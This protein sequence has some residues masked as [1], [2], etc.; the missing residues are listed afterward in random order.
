MLCVETI[1]K[2]RRYRLVEGKSIKAISREL[3]L[4]RNTVR[5]VLRERRL[6]SLFGN[7][8]DAW[9]DEKV[10]LFVDE[11]VTYG[12]EQVGGLRVRKVPNSKAPASSAYNDMVDDDIEEFSKP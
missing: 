1:G 6:E 12:G 5:R 10:V 7:D 8:T 4:S 3:R 2:I 9:V 11:E